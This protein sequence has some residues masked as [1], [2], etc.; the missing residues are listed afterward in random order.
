MSQGTGAEGAIPK[1]FRGKMK[2]FIK[3]VN[4]NL[5]GYRIEEFDGEK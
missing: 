2:I 5:K 4:V 1:L 3:R